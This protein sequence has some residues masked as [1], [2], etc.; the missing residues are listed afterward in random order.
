MKCYMYLIP[1]G[2]TLAVDRSAHPTTSQLV[3]YVQLLAGCLD[4]P[5]AARVDYTKHAT[6]TK[7]IYR[8]KLAHV[9]YSCTIYN[10]RV[11]L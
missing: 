11:L 7:G 10:S 6:T 8:Y 4:V 3:V 2:D 9:E 1:I 5:E